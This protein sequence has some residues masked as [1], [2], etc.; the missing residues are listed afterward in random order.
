M[1]LIETERSNWNLI[2]FGSKNQNTY[3]YIIY[4]IGL[5]LFICV[6]N[7]FGWLLAIATPRELL[8]KK[9]SFPLPNPDIFNLDH[10]NALTVDTVV[11]DNGMY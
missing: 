7:K 3:A 4:Y 2:E 11:S 9:V 1:Y 8:L 6:F 10:I 5:Q